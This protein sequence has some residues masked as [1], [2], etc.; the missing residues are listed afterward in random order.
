[1]VARR[2]LSVGDRV[3]YARAWLQSVVGHD[4]YNDLWRHKGVVIDGDLGGLDP[5]RFVRIRWDDGDESTVGVSNIAKIGSA[6]YAHGEAK[7]W[8]GYGGL[9]ERPTSCFKKGPLK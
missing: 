6:A 2:K 3:G 5:E 9:G 4:P 7:G 1:M 8:I